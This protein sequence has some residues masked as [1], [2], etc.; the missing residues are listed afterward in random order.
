MHEEVNKKKVLDAIPLKNVKYQ[1]NHIVL[2]LQDNQCRFCKK[3]LL[4]NRKL[5]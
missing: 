2:I 4:E 5:F 1:K 3:K